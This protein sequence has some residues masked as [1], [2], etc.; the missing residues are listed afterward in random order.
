MDRKR[1]TITL[2]KDFL[3]RLDALIDG[4]KI[5]NR[6]HAIEYLLSQSLL[7]KI[8]KAV[9]LAGGVGI[10]MRPLTYEIPKALISVHGTA[11]TEYTIALL[12]NFGIKNI[13]FAIGLLGN[14]IKEYFGDGSKHG[15]RIAYSEEKK[16]LGSAGAL[17][18]AKPLLK[19]RFLV[20]HGDILVKIDLNEFLNFHE[21]TKGVATMALF[22]A[23]DP[24]D[25]GTV[26]LSGGK[27]LD[28]IEKPKKGKQVSQLI[29]AGIYIF[30]PTVFKYIPKSGFFLLEDVFPKLAHQGKLFGFPIEGP[31]FDVS[32]PLEYERALKNWKKENII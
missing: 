13:I 12:R 10:K 24:S 16:A 2:R 9:I 8:E 3:K 25:Y 14:K 22:T 7:P 32:T 27:V 21:L 20:I 1:L 18:L 29:N 11:I 31:W 17:R 6:S 30:E 26:K 15:V 19:T 28:F 23:V 5:R 4:S